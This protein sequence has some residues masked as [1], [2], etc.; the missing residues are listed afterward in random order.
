MWCIHHMRTTFL[1]LISLL[2]KLT[3]KLAPV[4]H[5][6]FVCYDCECYCHVNLLLWCIAC[7]VCLLWLWVLLSWHPVAGGVLHSQFVC[8][9]CE[10]YCHVNPLL[11]YVACTFSCY[12]CECFYHDNMLLVVCCMHSLCVTTVSIIAWH[13]VARDA[14]A[15]LRGG[16]HG[17]DG[18]EHRAHPPRLLRGRVQASQERQLHRLP[19]NTCKC[20]CLLPACRF[21]CTAVSESVACQPSPV[22]CIIVCLLGSVELVIW[23]RLGL[24]VF[25]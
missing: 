18:A 25:V 19:G 20:T 24:R 11:W 12:N 13:P 6:Q 22:T 23:D 14:A 3:M 7:T 5:A 4:R 21:T 16:G 15:V 10:C 8:Y 17:E 9:D 2:S 1:F